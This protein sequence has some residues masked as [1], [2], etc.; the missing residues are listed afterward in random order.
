VRRA[1]SGVIILTAEF[2]L[3]FGML[4][5]SQNLSRAFAGTEMVSLGDVA[6]RAFRFQYM[7]RSDA[8]EPDF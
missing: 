8:M 3:K 5:T 7:K 6:Q 1:L 4:R 2:S